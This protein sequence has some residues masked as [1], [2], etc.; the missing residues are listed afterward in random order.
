MLATLV[1]DFKISFAPGYDPDTMWRDMED[2]V[3]AQPGELLCV[4]ER[5]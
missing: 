2:K 1:R 3:T 4:F 5:M